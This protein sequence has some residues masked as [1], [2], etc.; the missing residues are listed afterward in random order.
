MIYVE[1]YYLMFA[2]RSNYQQKSIN[3][4]ILWL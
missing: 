3:E 4:L 2:S 1:N